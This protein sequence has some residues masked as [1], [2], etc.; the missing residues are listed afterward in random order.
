MV[1]LSAEQT[2]AARA[3]YRL[4][5]AVWEEPEAF[6]MTRAVR[7]GS[8]DDLV[9]LVARRE[10]ARL[11]GERD[12]AGYRNWRDPIYG[13][14]NAR[15]RDAAGEWLARKIGEVAR[16]NPSRRLVPAKPRYTLPG[17]QAARRVLLAELRRHDF[18]KIARDYAA[19]EIREKRV[20]S[21]VG[22]AAVA[23]ARR[24]DRVREKVALGVMLL[25]SYLHEGKHARPASG[26]AL[27]AFWSHYDRVH[28]LS[29][30][31]PL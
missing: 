7:A 24:G 27:R 28:G 1:K 26:D 17:A 8:I 22:C 13:P 15:V 14:F 31:Y 16:P 29:G 6:S 20:A 3:L 2:R 30:K 18:D 25:A 9:E 11:R 5:F 23:A 21:R 10:A 12:R 4:A 19:G